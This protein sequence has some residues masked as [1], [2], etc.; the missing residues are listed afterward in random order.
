MSVVLNQTDTALLKTALDSEASFFSWMKNDTETFPNA[1]YDAIRTKFS[2]WRVAYANGELYIIMP[3]NNTQ[4]V[5]GIDE[6]PI[7]PSR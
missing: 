3:N 1:S 4:Q 6:I 7:P 5:S 2:N